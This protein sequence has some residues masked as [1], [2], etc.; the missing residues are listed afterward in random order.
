MYFNPDGSLRGYEQEQL[1]GFFLFDAA[2]AV[3]KAVGG[4]V[5]TVGKAVIPAAGGFLTAGPAGAI[6]AGGSSIIGSVVG[7]GGGGSAPQAT[8]TRTLPISGG[9]VASLLKLQQRAQAQR[10]AANQAGSGVVPISAST[11]QLLGGGAVP[12]LLVGAVLLLTM[13]K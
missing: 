11:A 3:G 9:F 8:S 7:G 2:K 4:A 1:E 10:L 5:K 13:R 12:L 6:A